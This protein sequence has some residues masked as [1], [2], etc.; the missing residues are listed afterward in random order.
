MKVGIHELL[1]PRCGEVSEVDIEIDVLGHGFVRV[2]IRF[3][4]ITTL[5]RGWVRLRLLVVLPFGFTCVFLA[6]IAACV[7]AF[8]RDPW[9]AGPLGGIG[10]QAKLFPDCVLAG[11]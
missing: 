7:A 1:K 10:S 5:A 9:A 6:T 3:S 4:S 11:A 2:R 8:A